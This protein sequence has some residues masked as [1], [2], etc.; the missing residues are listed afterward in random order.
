MIVDFI[1]YLLWGVVYGLTYP[2]RI[3][4]DVSLSADFANS[5]STFNNYLARLNFILPISTLITIIGIFI[6][7]EVAIFAYKLIMWLIRKIPTI[8]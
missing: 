4:A 1:L 5:I 7:I 6:G 3:L 2:I 8:N